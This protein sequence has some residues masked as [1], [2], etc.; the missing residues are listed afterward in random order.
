ML[1]IIAFFYLT[2]VMFAYTVIYL[3]LPVA[4]TS[5]CIQQCFTMATRGIGGT[6]ELNQVNK[7]AYPVLIEISVSTMEQGN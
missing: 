6:H 3:S 4:S 2:T 5:A 7:M 1:H